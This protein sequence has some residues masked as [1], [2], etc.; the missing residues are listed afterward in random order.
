VEL[1]RRG[2]A[3]SRER[4]QAEIAA[5]RVLVGGAIADKPARLVAAGE[6]L[7]LA[8]P[9]S[10]FVSRGGEKLDAALD[11]FGIEVA[12]RTALDAGAS[13]G[14]FS[15]CLL[16]HGA[17]SILAVDVGYGQLDQRLRRDPR[18]EVMERTNVRDLTP[19]ALAAAP[20]D[21]VTADLAF[22]SLRTVAPVLTSLAAP[23]GDLVMLVKPQFEAG[24]V[25]A[26]RGRGVI[27]DP[28]VWNRAVVG[29][30]DAFEAVGAAMMGVMVSPLL[31]AEGNVEFLGHFRRRPDG[32]TLREGEVAAVV[33]AAAR[34]VGAEA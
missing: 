14:G 32:P 34:R 9:P 17:S 13:T 18:V 27:R 25:E 8:G 2:L 24:R 15:H 26:S 12:G 29:V 6:P 4:A 7:Q 21:L 20:F 1:V 31:G 16:Q 10:R 11:R 22:V 3:P 19:A 28:E 23:D 33:A 30:R 5:G